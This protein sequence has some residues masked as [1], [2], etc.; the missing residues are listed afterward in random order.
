MIR[1][2]ARPVAHA[3]TGAVGA[4]P[5]RLPRTSLLDFDFVGRPSIAAPGIGALAFTRASTGYRRNASGLL[6]SMAA[7]VPRFDHHPGTLAPLGLLIEDARTN[8]GLRS[9]ELDNAA[10]SKSETT[11]SAN[12][13][14]APDGATTADKAVPSTANAEHVV[15]Q[16]ITISAGASLTLS[17]FAKAAG[18]G[19]FAVYAVPANSLYATFDL[20]AGVVAA[21]AVVGGGAIVATSIEAYG[22]GWHRCRLTAT[23]GADTSIPVRL[24]IT[25]SDSPAGF[26]GDGTSGV[27]FWGFQA[28]VGIFS[29][30]YI[31]TT[32][33]T[34][35][36]AADICT[37][38]LGAWFNAAEGTMFV[39]FDLLAV[40]GA[41]GGMSPMM[42]HDGTTA[43]LINVRHLAAGAAG[44][45]MVESGTQRYNLNSGTGTLVANAVVKTAH[46]WRVSD[47]SGSANGLG[48]V[49]ATHDTIPAFSAMSLGAALSG[50][51]NT[52]IGHIRRA[53]Y[54]SRRLPN[55]VLQSLTR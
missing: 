35:T 24:Q 19:K 49:T 7:D 31:K 42:F 54:W 43:N 44:V 26:A 18:N 6:E 48:P 17:V 2:L 39:E 55:T 37:M 46:A 8:L 22:G 41:F 36:R 47:Q 10:W 15:S 53:S 32:S 34:V 52:F 45:R 5:V 51:E 13:S 29:S 25:Q 30:S 11:V 4:T 40:G 38:P 23:F 27:L 20:A 50:A 33:A 28:E 1:T 21:S 9:E 3:R 14:V 12:A 16:T